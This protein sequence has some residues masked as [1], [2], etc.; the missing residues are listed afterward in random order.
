MSRSDSFKTKWASVPAQFERP[1]DAL[2]ERGWAGGA[3]EDPPEA[4]WEN[5]WHN[6]V[7]EALAEIE[8][9]GAPQWFADVAYTVGATS[10]HDGKNY[11]AKIPSQ[12]IEPGSATD[13]GHWLNAEADLAEGSQGYKLTVINGCIALEEII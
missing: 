2:I 11:V 1:T 4:K 7:D 9:N 10:R 12:G 3:A 8:A 6:R 13:N 5:W